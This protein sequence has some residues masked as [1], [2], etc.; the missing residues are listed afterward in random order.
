MACYYPSWPHHSPDGH[1]THARPW[2]CGQCTGCRLEKSREWATRIMHEASLYTHNSFITLTYDDA[3]LPKN[4]SLFYRDWQLFMKRLRKYAARQMNLTSVPLSKHGTLSEIPSHLIPGLER[5]VEKIPQGKIRFYM[6]GEYGER[7]QRPHYH[8]AL[9]NYRFHDEEIWK[10]SPAGEQ[11]YTSQTLNKL[12]GN[13][14]NNTTGKLTFQSAAYIARYIMKKVTGDKA[15]SHYAARLD[16]ETGEIEMR[17]PEF[18]QMS[19]MP[20]I[21]SGWL[22]KFRDDV[23]PE[24]VVVINGQQ[25][26][27]PRYYD[28]KYKKQEPE[29]YEQLRRKRL[30]EAIKTSKDKTE[31]RLKTRETVHKAKIKHL[32]RGLQ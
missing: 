7:T 24:G 16:P 4:A 1:L 10:K 2:P 22:E 9:F 8:A 18:N 25:M 21:G 13:G 14:T 15:Q 5:P 6:S 11:M 3:H 29:M 31:P 23:Y 19:R 26:P 17:R 32:K 20:G 12:W 28:D 27:A 30:A